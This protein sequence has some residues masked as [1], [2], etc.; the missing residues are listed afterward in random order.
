MH[1]VSFIYQE[2]SEKANQI[3]AKTE[4]E[5][6]ISKKEIFNKEQITIDEQYDRKLRHMNLELMK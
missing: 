3:D 1:M 6:N 5:I 4:E 2:G